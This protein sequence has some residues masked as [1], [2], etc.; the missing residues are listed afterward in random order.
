[1][2]VCGH[3]LKPKFEKGTLLESSRV[4]NK[5]IWGFKMPS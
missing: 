3:D 2:S 5:A 4:F 1:M